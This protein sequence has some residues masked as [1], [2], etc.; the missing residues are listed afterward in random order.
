MNVNVTNVFVKSNRLEL[1]DRHI[2][3]WHNHAPGNCDEKRW[4]WRESVKFHISRWYVTLERWSVTSDG[5]ICHI[6]KC[7]QLHNYGPIVLDTFFCDSS[8]CNVT[9]PHMRLLRCMIG[10][11]KG[12]TTGF[13]KCG[14]RRT[15]LP[16]SDPTSGPKICSAARM[17]ALVTGQLGSWLVVTIFRKCFVRG[18]PILICS[19]RARTAL[20]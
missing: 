13:A 19:S 17:S 14:R 6:S 3:R 11:C 16:L 18:R 15:V 8:H 1:C 9:K 12:S 20:R 7:D 2:D 10:E 4:H 5:V